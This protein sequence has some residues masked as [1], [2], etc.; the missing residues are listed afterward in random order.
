MDVAN[1]AS[2]P[3]PEAA[4]APS[5]SVEVD[6]ASSVAEIA[7]A[8]V[9]PQPS[10]AAA[11]DP[12]A[13]QARAAAIALEDE[14][15]ARALRRTPFR[16]LI[17][18]P[19]WAGLLGAG[20][21]MWTAGV[22]QAFTRAYLI[23]RPS[24]AVAFFL[25]L[26]MAFGFALARGYRTPVQGYGS[27]LGRVLAVS[28]FGGILA[29]IATIILAL[30]F[31][32]FHVRGQ[33]A[34]VTIALVGGVLGGLSLA[35]LHGIG[36]DKSRRIKIASVVAAAFLLTIWPSAPWLRCRLGSGEGCREA[37]GRQDDAR[38]MGRLAQ[39]GCERE[40][41]ES[42]RLA[43]LAYQQEGPARDLRRA[44]SFYREGCSLGDEESCNSV[45]ELELEQRCDR[46]GAFACAELAHA[47]ETGDGMTRDRALAQRYYRKAC[48][49]G[50]DDACRAAEGR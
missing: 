40:D 22:I 31:D 1:E 2:A 35:R 21:G 14:A 47:H 13:D 30:F 46:Y 33:T 48:L 43:G 12:A 41:M 16:T 19:F 6:A 10:V 32:G 42:C 5:E 17:T 25:P 36:T 7:A 27:L 8:A 20:A 45:H 9:E 44:E 29:S 34:Y 49:L 11:V 24:P 15:A 39:I 28:L 50:A 3:E 18:R 26:I 37:A 23:P 4:V 38:S